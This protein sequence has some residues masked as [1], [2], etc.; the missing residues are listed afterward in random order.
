MPG[1]KT[2]Q[3][4]VFKE[5]VA[6]PVDVAVDDDAALRTPKH[7]AAAE[8]VVDGAAVGAGLGRVCF[9]DDEHF[10]TCKLGRFVDEPLLEAVMGPG[11][12]RSGCLGVDPPMR[13][14]DHLAG[15]KGR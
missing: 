3:A 15:L 9:V 1:G 7:L 8:L 12:H 14:R 5:D 13:A 10:A 2:H 6:R 4:H 11:H